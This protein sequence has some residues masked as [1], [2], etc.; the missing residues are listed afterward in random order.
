MC[1]FTL[2]IRGGTLHNKMGIPSV[3]RLL[4]H[5]TRTLESMRMLPLEVLVHYIVVIRIPC[6][7][8]I[9][10]NIWDFLIKQVT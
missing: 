8:F 2:V 9:S 3:F 1:I 10:F 7:I 6:L 5:T 4:V